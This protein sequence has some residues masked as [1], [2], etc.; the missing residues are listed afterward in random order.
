[1]K[2]M[3]YVISIVKNLFYGKFSKKER[4]EYYI[5]GE[6]SLLRRRQFLDEREKELKKFFQKTE[7]LLFS[8]NI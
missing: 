2:L 7:N 5:E 1:M 4:E 3:S 6:A 8:K